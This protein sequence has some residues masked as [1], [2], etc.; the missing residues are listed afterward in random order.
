MNLSNLIIGTANLTSAY[1]YRNKKISS[2]ETSKIFKLMNKYKINYIDTAQSYGSSEKTLGK[3]SKGKK[4]FTKFNIPNDN[5]NK[6]VSHINFLINESFK[7]LKK[8]EIEGILIHNS[9]FFL[10]KKINQIKIIRL[11]KKYKREKKIKKIGFSIYSPRELNSITK[12][13]IPDFFQI[14][15]NILDQRFL[16]KKII[17]K[18]NNNKIEIHARSIFSQGK[19]LSKN[20]FKSKI[21]N[22][23]INNFYTWCILN[24]VSRISACINFIRNYKFINKII[25]G[26]DDHSQL[27]KIIRILNNNNFYVPKKFEVKNYKLIDP[28]KAK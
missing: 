27:M 18:I 23:K 3:L 24:N 11:L 25:V 12:I 7:K 10:K 6:I 14:P 16:K 22:R 2:A 26:I 9:D 5:S 28:R 19:I 4:I 20:Q 17:D 1:G 13:F 15:V 8:R 21:V